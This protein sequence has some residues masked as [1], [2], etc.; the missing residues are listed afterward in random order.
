MYKIAPSDQVVALGCDDLSHVGVPQHKIGIRANSDAA[1]A[2]EQV[3][4]LSCVCASHCHKLVLIH[5]AS[6]LLGQDIKS[7][8]RI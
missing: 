4:D 3:E 5:L 7:N 2:G 8:T 6:H 1:L